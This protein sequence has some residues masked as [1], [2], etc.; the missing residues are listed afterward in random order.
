MVA[1]LL[2]GCG[3]S[4]TNSAALPTGGLQAGAVFEHRTSDGSDRAIK[5]VVVIIQ[6]NRSMDNLFYGYPNADTQPYGYNEKGRRIDLKPVGLQAEWDLEHDSNAFFAACNGRGKIPGTHCRMNGFDEIY[7]GCGGSGEPRCPNAN[8][9]YSYVPHAETKPYFAMA[10]QY[11]LG[12]RM[13][14]SDFDLSSVVSHQYII[15][16]QAD[17][18]INFATGPPGCEGGSDDTMYTINQK[19]RI[20]GVVPVCFDYITLGAEL[21]QAKLSWRYYASSIYGDGGT[22]SAYQAVKYV[23]DG[24]D[25]KK[26]VISPQTEFFSDVKAGKLPVVSWITPTCENSDHSGCGSKTGPSWVAALV[27]A[28]G[29]SKYW[30]STAIFVFWDEAGGWYDHVPP[31]YVDYDGLGMRVPL[32]IVSAYAK[33]NYVSHLRYEHGSILKFIE[34]RFGLA[35]MS[36]SDSRANSP[37]KDCFDFSRPPRKFTPIPAEYSEDYLLRRPPDTRPPDTE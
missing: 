19:R 8:P 16:A 28:I 32:L 24:P 6:E 14:A 37:E 21:D 1:A 26:D 35:P 7:Y 36:A 13:F 9:P 34:Q 17:G 3:G 22:W 33:Q 25:W 10:R 2:A 5:H 18:T 29:E 11:V 31:P 20:D 15:A 23:Y 4:Q 12:D 30:D 27:N